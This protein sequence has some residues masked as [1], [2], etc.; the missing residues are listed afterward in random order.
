MYVFIS[1]LEGITGFYEQNSKSKS[2]IE[3][4]IPEMGI[5]FF[6]DVAIEVICEIRN[7]FVGS[8]KCN[9]HLQNILFDSW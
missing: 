3:G 6:L 4:D 2:K 9:F 7:R 8:C 5:S 1:F